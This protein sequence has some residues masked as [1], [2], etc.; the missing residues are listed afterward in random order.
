MM[1]WCDIKVLLKTS[2]G[3][4]K[5]FDIYSNMKRLWAISA[6][7]VFVVF[8]VYLIKPETKIK[9]TVDYSRTYYSSWSNFISLIVRLPALL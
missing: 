1:R 5:L 4:N 3:K 6:I 9:V 7:N 2:R 8:G